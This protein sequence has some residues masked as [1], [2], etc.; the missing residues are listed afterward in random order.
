MERVVVGMSGGVDSAVCAYLLKMQ[1]YDVYGVTLRT[2]VGD[3]GEE[4]RCCE[5]NDAR[6]IAD[7]LDIPYYVHDCQAEFKS[8]VTDPFITDYVRG[9][10]PNP[11]IECNR[12][13]KWNK[14]IEMADNLGA[15]YVATGH[16]ATVEQL[17]NNRY[18]VKRADSLA[19]DQTYMLYKLTQ[20]QLSRTLMPL[21][22]LTKEEVRRVAKAAG[23]PVADKADSQEIC[24]VSDDDY[25]GYIEANYD[26][27]L[28][29]EGDFVDE[30]GNVL[31]RHK[32]VIHY[33]VG[34]RKG[35]G[36]AFGHPMYVKRIDTARNEVI[37]SDNESLFTDIVVCS[38]INMMGIPDIDPGT[39]IRCRAKVRYRHEPEDAY[40][41]MDE[42]GHLVIKFDKPV[43]AAA[44][45][46]SAV[47][48]DEN[49]CIIGGG[50]II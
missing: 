47:M 26:G 6:A 20:E 30:D 35:L 8:C 36:I 23:I 41:C 25:A 14:M 13:L 18:T 40:A 43:R 48:Y 38:D 19:K 50:I 11:C 22:P 44:P 29:G 39:K 10:T 34:Q 42:G 1:G 12:K 24:F 37:L 15:S 32:G 46:Q 16:Y 27:P 9:I 49:D 28:P 33:T 3:S 2:W 17:P 21:G 5:I 45:G 7:A 4:S 31:G